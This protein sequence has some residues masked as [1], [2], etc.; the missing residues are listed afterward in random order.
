MSRPFVNDTGIPFEKAMEC[1]TFSKNNVTFE[2]QLG[3]N[4]AHNIVSLTQDYSA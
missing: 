2:A 3:R 1:K 4:E